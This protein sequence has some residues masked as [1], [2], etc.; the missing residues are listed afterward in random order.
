[1]ATYGGPETYAVRVADDAMAPR[2]RAGDYVYVDPE[3]SA[4]DGVLVAVRGADPAAGSA[5]RRLVVENGRR[6][7]RAANAGWPDI[8]I[9]RDNETMI[10]GTAVMRGETI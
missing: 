10:L 3:Q 7:L 9:T 5:V 8:E 6:V 1:M 2:L 4:V